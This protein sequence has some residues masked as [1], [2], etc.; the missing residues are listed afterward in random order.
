[1]TTALWY[2]ESLPKFD[3]NGKFSA[4]ANERTRVVRNQISA[5]EHMS[6][7]KG[8]RKQFCTQASLDTWNS[9]NA[10]NMI[11]RY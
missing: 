6:K 4:I 7:N 10:R 8:T 2:F 1:M 3:A 9:T 11:N 5:E